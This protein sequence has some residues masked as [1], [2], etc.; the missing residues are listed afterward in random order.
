MIYLAKYQEEAGYVDGFVKLGLVKAK[1]EK[2]A[3]EKAAKIITGDSFFDWDAEHFE[4]VKRHLSVVAVD[5][6]FLEISREHT[7]YEG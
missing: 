2:E 6:G 4:F 1:S 5:G 3:I 7:D